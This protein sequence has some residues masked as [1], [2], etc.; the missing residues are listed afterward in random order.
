VQER[1]LLGVSASGQWLCQLDDRDFPASRAAWCQQSPAT[2]RTSCQST[3][4]PAVSAPT[5]R[6]PI[7]WAGPPACGSLSPPAAGWRRAPEP[8]PL[9]VTIGAGDPPFCRSHRPLASCGSGSRLSC[10]GGDGASWLPGV[11]PGA[12]R[13]R[14][15]GEAAAASC[16]G[17]GAD[18][19]CAGSTRAVPR[20]RTPSTRSSRAC[21]CTRD[22]ARPAVIAAR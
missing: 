13:R 19:G 18:R 15:A 7:T 2:E 8:R 1:H 4:S 20:P 5:A 14:Q 16:G 10:F 9:R 3:P 22:P 12:G 6:L 11:P 17:G 21:R